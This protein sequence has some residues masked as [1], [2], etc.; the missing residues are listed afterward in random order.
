MSLR[1]HQSIFLKNV[2][3]LITWAFE[4]GYELTGGELYRTEEQQNIYRKNGTS[5]V[6]VSK[7]QKRLA[8]DLNLFIDGI[9]Q[10]KTKPTESWQ[11]IGKVCIQKIKQA[12][13]GDGT[14]I[15]LK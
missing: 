11:R 1:K 4:Q 14:A 9:Y 3:K 2:A 13:I 5:K 12:M 7:H 6:Q 15:T 8:I 10:T